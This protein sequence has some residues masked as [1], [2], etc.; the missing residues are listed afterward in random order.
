MHVLQRPAQNNAGAIE[1]VLPHGT[2]PDDVELSIVIPAM[3]EEITVGEFMEWCKKG[4]ECAGVSAQILIVD[5]ST[6]RTPEIVLAHGGEVLRTPKRGLGRAYIDASAYIRGQAR[7]DESR[8]TLE[9]QRTVRRKSAALEQRS[10]AACAVTTLLDLSAVGVEDAIV[11]RAVRAAW[12]LEQQRL[13]ETDAG[14]A[15]GERAQP[16]RGKEGVRDRRFEHHE[17]VADPVHL[18]EFDAHWLGA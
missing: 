6:D 2:T 3:N 16:L 12:R 18:R 5:S 7:A 8:R 9:R 10:D 1:H 17:V 11:G 14:A 4:I 15:V 13:I